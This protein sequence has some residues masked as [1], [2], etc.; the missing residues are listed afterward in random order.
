MTEA[1]ILNSD[2]MT[3]VDTL[4]IDLCSI[5]SKS[6]IKLTD[7]HEIYLTVNPD[8]HYIADHRARSVFWLVDVNLGELDPD[9]KESPCKSIGKHS[10]DISYRA[11]ADGL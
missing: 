4:Y 1:N 7:N 11:A 8:K 6:Q 2:V 9:F 3:R 10:F 5:V